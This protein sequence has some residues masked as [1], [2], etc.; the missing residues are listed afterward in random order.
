MSSGNSSKLVERNF[1]PKS[2]NLTESGSNSPFAS[3]SS[4]IVRN[5]YISKISPF[6]PG[7]FCLNSTGEPNLFFTI[8]AAKTKIGKR[9]TKAIPDKIM[10]INR[11]KYLLYI[12]KT[13][14]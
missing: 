7:R 1:L 2:V 13:I 3:R 6:R 9:M 10:S 14:L 4:V 11:L 12:T 8:Y 5:L